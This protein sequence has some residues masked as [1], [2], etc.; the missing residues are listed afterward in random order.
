MCGVAG[1][2]RL[3]VGE[4]A[5]LERVRAMCDVMVHRGP[6]SH[7]DY[8]NAE[9]VQFFGELNSQFVD[10]SFL[11]SVS[12]VS[13]SHSAGSDSSH[14]ITGHVVLSTVFALVAFNNTS[15]SQVID[16][17][18]SPMACRNVRIRVSKCGAGEAEHEDKS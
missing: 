14:F 8:A 2:L 17:F 10:G 9:V 4:R 11:S 12:F 1:E 16:S 3:S 7:G 18:V 6:D 5:S 15:F 13:F